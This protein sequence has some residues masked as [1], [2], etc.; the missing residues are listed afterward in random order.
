[1]V[2]GSPYLYTGSKYRVSSIPYRKARKGVATTPFG[3]RVIKSTSGGRGLNQRCIS[4]ERESLRNK[5]FVLFQLSFV[6]YTTSYA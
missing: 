6:V 3:G 5:C 1:M 2:R 4:T